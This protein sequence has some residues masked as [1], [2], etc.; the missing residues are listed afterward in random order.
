MSQIQKQFYLRDKIITLIELIK[1]MIFKSQL[2]LRI[3]DIIIIT[4]KMMVFN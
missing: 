3:M 4:L 2:N 1:S